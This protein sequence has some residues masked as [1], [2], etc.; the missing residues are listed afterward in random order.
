MECDVD[1]GVVGGDERRE[2]GDGQ[3]DCPWEEHC[4][5]ETVL[6]LDVGLAVLH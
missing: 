6:C 2:E 1:F 4:G 3:R 5:L